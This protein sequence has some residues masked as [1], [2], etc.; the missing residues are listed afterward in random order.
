MF[1]I[2]A[3]RKYRSTET[4]LIKVHNDFAAAIDIRDNRLF[5]FY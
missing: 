4:A 2:S 3:Y 1:P 5:S